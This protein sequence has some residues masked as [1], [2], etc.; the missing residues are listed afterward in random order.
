MRTTAPTHNHLHNSKEQA[1]LFLGHPHSWAAE[2]R[3][4]AFLKVY[5]I[6][7]V[8]WCALLLGTG[9]LKAQPVAQAEY[10]PVHQIG[11]GLLADATVASL[12]YERLLTV[13][14]DRVLVAAKAGFG[15]NQTLDL[16]LTQSCGGQS[17]TYLAV[18]HHVTANFGEG[19]SFLEVGAGATYLFSP[20]RSVYV[21]YLVLGYRHRPLRPNKVGLR[22][23]GCIPVV[24]NQLDD[25]S[26][27]P[28]GLSLGCCF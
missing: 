19:R 20:T 6:V 7:C 22:L 12:Y 2:K 18:P 9:T 13:K 1:L 5:A 8:G 14:P 17:T 4:A 3:S 11:I 10:R 27:F 16:C 26:F 15:Y 28:V 25:V 23:Y 21:P 24:P